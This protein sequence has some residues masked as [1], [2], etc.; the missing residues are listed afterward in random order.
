[1]GVQDAHIWGLRKFIATDTS[2]NSSEE[3]KYDLSIGCTSSNQ[4]SIPSKTYIYIYI[5]KKSCKGNI[6]E[7]CKGT[8]M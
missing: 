1:M 7:H 6:R 5:F 2:K 4:L 3:S 8:R